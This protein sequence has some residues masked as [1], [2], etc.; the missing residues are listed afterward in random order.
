MAKFTIP[1]LGLGLEADVL[2]SRTGAEVA[3]EEINKTTLLNNS[4]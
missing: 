4:L 2:Y 1:V 3:G